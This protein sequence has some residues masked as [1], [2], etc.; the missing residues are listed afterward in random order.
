M[1]PPGLWLNSVRW[2]PEPGDFRSTTG[3]PM[4]M[5]YHQLLIGQVTIS[6]GWIIQLFIVYLDTVVINK[7]KLEKHCYWIP[8]RFSSLYIMYAPPHPWTTAK[9]NTIAITRCPRNSTITKGSCTSKK[10]Y[11]TDGQQGNY[12]CTPKETIPINRFRSQQ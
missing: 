4:A 8:G 9:K 10:L 1:A 3:V 5:W 2:W 11:I 12:T 7:E 6:T